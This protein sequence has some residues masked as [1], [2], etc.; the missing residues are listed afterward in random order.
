MKNKKQEKTRQKIRKRSKLILPLP[1]ESLSIQTS[2]T[3]LSLLILFHT[4]FFNDF[5]L[6]SEFRT[7]YELSKEI[8]SSKKLY[9]KY[10]SFKK[11]KVFI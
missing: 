8:A 3:N 5:L 4:K 1:K 2:D 10:S 9:K 6:G 7:Y 11:N